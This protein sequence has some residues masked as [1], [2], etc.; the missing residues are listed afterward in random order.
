MLKNAHYNYL[1]TVTGPGHASVYTGTTP[2]YHGI[3]SNEWYDRGESR[4][5]NCVEDKKQTAVGTQTGKGSASP[6]RLKTTTI[7][8]E[9][10]A[11]TQEQARVIGISLK[12]RGAIL[13]SGHLSDGAYWYDGTTGNFISS[14][15]YKPGLP[16]WVDQ[17]NQFKLADVR[18][19][20]AEAPC[21]AFTNSPEGELPAALRHTRD[22]AV[23]RQLAEAEAAQRELAHVGA[24]T[25]APA[26]PVAVPNF[27]LQ[28]LALTRFLRG[29]GHGRSS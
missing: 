11:A 1:P 21:R 22:V 3:I 29:S 14:S 27:E 26:A 2:S 28:G 16:V 23:E 4:M 10:K 19:L 12:D 7:T 24:R 25:P 9:L 8:D 13:P 20:V 15:Y 17:F 18:G 6:W 5:V